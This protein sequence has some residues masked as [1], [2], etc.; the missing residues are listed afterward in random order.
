M[1]QSIMDII[2]GAELSL[3]DLSPTTA[4]AQDATISA[5]SALPSLPA[6]CTRVIVCAT[7][8]AVRWKPNDL[9]P[10]G[11]AGML[12]PENTSVLFVGTN[13]E[14]AQLHFIEAAASAAID[15]LYFR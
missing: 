11:T 4:W 12:I 13:A 9:V 8:D 1:V 15:C 6:D 14:L 7:G 3:D 5:S 2:R 10:T